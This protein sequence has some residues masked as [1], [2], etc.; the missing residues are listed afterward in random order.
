MLLISEHLK[1]IGSVDTGDF[2]GKISRSV[3]FN[4]KLP[5]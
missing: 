3:S 2:S 5:F 4:S 1:V